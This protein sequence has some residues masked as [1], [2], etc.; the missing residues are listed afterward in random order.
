MKLG[1]LNCPKEIL[2][3]LPYDVV[4]LDNLTGEL[5]VDSLFIDWLPRNLT[6]QDKLARQASIVETCAKNKKTVVLFDRYLDINEREYK[7]LK[8]FNTFFFEP[9]VNYREGFSFLPPWT[10]CYDLVELPTFGGKEERSIDLG[11]IGTLKNRLKS[12][13]KYYVEFAELY[14]K[15]NISYTSSLPK[16][17]IDEYRDAGVTKKEFAFK[18]IKCFILI[19]TPR[20]YEIGYL[21]PDIFDIM[22]MGCFPILPREHRF[23]HSVFSVLNEIKF[24]STY[25]EAWNGVREV[26][27]L[28]IY[29]NIKTVFPE[30]SIEYAVETIKMCIEK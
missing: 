25:I 22:Q 7:Y 2:E 4:H 1:V 8:K 3:E 15:Y 13:E 18:D 6:D 16:P 10:K 28:D 30:M 19:D 29:D 14:P 12:F 24:I 5:D 21:N 20:N 9:A 23:Y 11:Y 26:I 27:L 17:K